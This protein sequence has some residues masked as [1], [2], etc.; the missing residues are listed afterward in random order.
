MK[1]TFFSNFLNH[2]QLPFCLEMQNRLGDKFKFVA[3]EKVPDDRLAL[4]YDDM[5][6][7]YDFVVRAYEDEEEAYRLGLDS[8]VVIIGSAPSKYIKERLKKGK[9]MFRYSERIFRNGFNF[10]KWLALIKNFTLMEH[11]N[12]YLLCS[13][14]YSAYD[15]N[16]AGAYI[17][18]SFKWGYFP[19]VIKYNINEL[20]EK[21]NKSKTIKIIWVARFLALKHPEKVIEIAK[22]LRNDK[23]NFSIKMIGI[24]PLFDQT[25]E[26]I[27]QNNLEDKVK[28]LG[29]I[30]N[31]EVRKHMD[32]ANIFLFTSDYNE[33]WGAVVNEAMNSGCAVV[34]SH[35]IG[36][37][38]FLI[39]HKKNG[40]I[41]KDDSIDDLYNQVKFLIDNKE[42]RNKI[43]KN[44]Y[45]TMIKYWNASY[46]TEELL[47]ISKKLLN[48]EKKTFLDGV[49]P[50]SKAYSIKE[51]NMYDFCVQ[52]KEDV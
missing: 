33:G 9:L 37:V 10:K 41:Y 11:K 42:Q 19:E 35:A 23:V 26:M 18:K 36:S 48:G 22:R 38:P 28:L 39:N 21:K 3:T 13:S 31:K 49:G 51:K 6:K 24:G 14:A 40:L 5:N 15:F 16:L 25:K 44:A 45:K 34:A 27:K 2:H 17:N 7:A 8:D 12:V 1:I 52:T 43:S 20:L 46:A 32:E 47:K 30:N 29:A 50:C 4:G